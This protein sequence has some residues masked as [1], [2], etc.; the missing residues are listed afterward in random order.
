MNSL[1]ASNSLI[2]TNTRNG[3][4]LLRVC[5]DREAF[6][7][8]PKALYIDGKVLYH[9]PKEAQ[10]VEVQKRLWKESLVCAGVKEDDT[11]LEKW[12]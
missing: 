4:D 2:R 6:G 11:V 8:Y 10:D 12:E 7:E 5:F 9:A 1:W 3:D